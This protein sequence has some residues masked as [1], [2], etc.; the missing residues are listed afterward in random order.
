MDG[1]RKEGPTTDGREE[2]RECLGDSVDR[3]HRSPL[4]AETHPIEEGQHTLISRDINSYFLKMSE[5]RA[6]TTVRDVQ[7]EAF[8]KAY[9][10]HM[11]R[12]SKINPPEWTDMVK[13]ATWKDTGPIEMDWY[14]TRAAAI[15][16]KIYLK[17][18]GL[19]QLLRSFGG[20]AR[21]GTRTNKTRK[22]SGSVIRHALK[23][24]ERAGVVA[25]G[26]NGG[27]ILTSKGQKDMDLIA[28]QA[29]YA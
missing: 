1:P 18:S 17:P 4:T 14:F 16:R 15:A 12:S 3:R 27:R 21:R 25:K 28:V 22:A 26:E 2:R 7:A 5:E 8:I 11:K 20:G 9:A 19:G 6:S 13:T 10:A 23:E 29:R 24:L